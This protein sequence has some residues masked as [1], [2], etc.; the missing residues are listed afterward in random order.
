MSCLPATEEDMRKIKDI[1]ADIKAVRAEAQQVREANAIAKADKA[2]DKALDAMHKQAAKDNAAWDKSAGQRTA[3][4][5]RGNPT[6]SMTMD[7]GTFFTGAGLCL[8]L[9]IVGLTMIA[10]GLADWRDGR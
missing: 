3:C 9:A 1:Q 10:K 4:P 8:A 6:R 2:Q 5:G 7:A